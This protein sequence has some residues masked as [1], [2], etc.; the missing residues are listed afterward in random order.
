MMNEGGESYTPVVAKTPANNA[1]GATPEVAELGESRGVPNW[2]LQRDPKLRAL[3]RDGLHEKLAQIRRLAST[4]HTVRFVTLWHHVYDCDRLAETFFRLKKDGAVGVDKVDWTQYEQHLEDNI[5]AL[6]DCLRRG[7]YHA[8]LVRRAYIPKPDGR[9]RPLGIITLEDKLV[10]RVMADVLAVIYEPMFHDFSYGF[11]PGRGQHDALDLVTVSLEQEKMSWVLDVDIRA[12]FDT[13]DHDWLLKFVEHRI[14]DTRIIRHIK[15]WLKAGVLEEGEVQVPESGTPQGGSISPLLATV[16]LHY[17]LDNWA[18]IWKRDQAR[19][20]LRIVRY[21]DDI[22]ICFQYRDDAERFRREAH[23]RLERFHLALHPEK[24][25][26]I[27]F[28]RFAAANRQQRGDRKP[29]TF[30]FLGF[31][32]I[33]ST[34]RAGRFCVLRITRRKK[35]QAKLKELKQDLRERISEPLPDIGQWLAQ[36]V[37]GYYRYYGVPRNYPALDS[38]RTA[39]VKLWKKTLGRRSQQGY[40]TWERMNRL[41]RRWLPRPKIMHPY[42]N[43]RVT[44]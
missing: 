24:T 32:H 3:I 6:S 17:V 14:A 22:V 33:C 43:T 29:E 12:F 26:L 2:N 20:A 7:A 19:G 40:I 5:R 30:D 42:P 36:V 8:N 35:R 9:L 1:A 37:G 31:T 41:A 44:V 38:F 23:T 13:I 39:V 10:Q 28:G 18:A 27:E 16:Y 15:K 21:A 11:R 25:R 4:D 34:T